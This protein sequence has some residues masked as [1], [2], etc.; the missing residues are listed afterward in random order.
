[1]PLF[2]SVSTLVSNAII[3]PLAKALP[4][5]PDLWL[6][7]APAGR[8]EGNSK[9]LYLWLN[10]NGQRPRPVW[11]TSDAALARRLR[12]LGLLAQSSRSLAGMRLAARAGTL[13]V[14][15]NS[16]DVHFGL[17]AGARVFN[18]WHG[19][20]LKNV[21]FGSSVGVSAALRRTARGALGGLRSMRRLQRP[22]WIL[23]T[24]PE[25]SSGFFA[26][27]FDVPSERAPAL[28][29]PRLDPQL[30][31]A[32]KEFALSFEDYSTVASQ[33]G[34]RAILYAPTLREGGSGDFLAQAL[35]DLG[36]LSKSLAQQ[37]ARLFLKLHPKMTGA[38][39]L[40]LPPAI[41][42]LPDTMDLYPVLD[43]FDALIT[44]YSSLFFDW[45]ATRSSGV[46][47][48]SFDLAE[49]VRVE[50]DLAWDYDEATAGER[51]GSFA[52]LCSVIADGR[53]FAPIDP[54]RLQLLRERFW[55]GELQLPTSS[56]R[57]R[58]FVMNQQIGR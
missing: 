57:I 37:K 8:F 53:V 42:L 5:D 19:V 50:R 2:K 55:G 1:M 46:V 47:L 10:Q 25:M 41:T 44:D 43:R 12:A 52:E 23:S 9:Y 30:D 13:F 39:S 35:P 49:Y 51:A 26:R 45:I 20:G 6:F 32:L 38:K 29:Y 27:C 33:R 11:L 54:T 56:E 15:D 3:Y 7:G 22:D 18:L 16:S 31:P 40:T 36:R 21:M 14:N 58:D 48:Y 28:G 17:T 34:E 24:S 4:R